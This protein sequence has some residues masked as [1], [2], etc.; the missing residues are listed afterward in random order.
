LIVISVVPSALFSTWTFCMVIPFQQSV[1]QTERDP[2]QLDPKP[3]CGRAQY[4]I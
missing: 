4:A 1:R 3:R 2:W